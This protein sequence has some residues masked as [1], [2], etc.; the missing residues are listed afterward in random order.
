MR[1]E[2]ARRQDEAMQEEEAMA[3]EEEAMRRVELRQ[4]TPSDTF[5]ADRV[6]REPD[7]PPRRPRD[8]DPSPDGRR[9]PRCRSHDGGG[10]GA[11]GGE[12]PSAGTERFD[13]RE[14]PLPPT[15]P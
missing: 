3:Q 14:Q 12:R 6:K 1:E 13:R 11:S 9:S 2:E 7:D 5:D 4:D 10:G 15:P 8:G